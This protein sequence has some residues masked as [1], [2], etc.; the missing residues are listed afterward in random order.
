M[1]ALALLGLVLAAC[2]GAPSVAPPGVTIAAYARA[3]QAGD[4][5]GAYRLLGARARAHLPRDRFTALL[6]ENRADVLD[7]TRALVAREHARPTP[8][9]ARLVLASGE[10][11]ILVL[12]HGAWRVDAG[13]LDA[14]TL[15][16]PADAVLALRRALARRSLDAVLRVLSRE[17]RA[18]VFAA[19]TALVDGASD[20][21]DLHTEI[22]GDTAHVTLTGGLVV[23]LV[24]ESAEWRVVDVE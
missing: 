10:A 9:E 2:G 8:A 14:P 6:L 4:A 24:R 23:T 3:I 17:Q 22:D 12:E 19:I 15:A 5:D 21:A 7:A 1:R 11:V 13:V 16:T 18:E 20:P